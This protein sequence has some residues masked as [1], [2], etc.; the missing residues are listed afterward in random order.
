VEARNPAAL[1]FLL[2]LVPLLV[3]IVQG[4][5]RS[6]KS[7]RQLGGTWRYRSLFNVFLV[8]TFFGYLFFVLFFLFGV[9][10]LLDIY[11][12]ERLAEDDRSGYEVVFAVDVSRSMLARDVM[13]SRL[14]RAVTEIRRFISQAERMRF[15]LVA[16]KGE[17]FCALP[18]T[19]DLYSLDVVLSSFSPAMMSSRGSNLEE[20]I[21]KALDTFQTAGRYSL[22]LLFTDGESL[23]GD[24]VSAAKLAERK[25]IPIVPVALGTERGAEIVLENGQ[26]VVDSRNRRVI[27]RLN[28]HLLEQIADISGARVYSIE[29]MDRLW[30]ELLSIMKNLEPEEAQQGLKLVKRDYYRLFLSLA[31]LFLTLSLVIR[32]VRWRDTV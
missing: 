25:S 8:K 19:E 9:V 26:R 18:I 28:R 16:F 29:E 7:I 12:G 20:G 5:K 17:A 11:W 27:S 3:V 13:P 1:W 30:R 10:S 31:L 14:E 23:T 21:R 15:G 32:G 2:A 22:V 4:Y 24:A 6:R